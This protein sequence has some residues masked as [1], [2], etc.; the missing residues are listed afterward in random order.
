MSGSRGLWLVAQSPLRGK[1]CRQGLTWSP[2]VLPHISVKDLKERI[3]MHPQGIHRWYRTAWPPEVSSQLSLQFPFWLFPNEEAFSASGCLYSSG[4][5]HPSH[6][7]S[8][9]KDF[10]H[11]ETES[12]SQGFKGRYSATS[13]SFGQVF[14][15][16]FPKGWYINHNLW[17]VSATMGFFNPVNQSCVTALWY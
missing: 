17:R 4:S 15:C 3:V 16:S 8:S 6:V 5:H 13:T 7:A 14:H 9:A 1:W 12:Y 10:Q 2:P 11:G